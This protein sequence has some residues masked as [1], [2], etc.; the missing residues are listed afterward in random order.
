VNPNQPISHQWII[1][2]QTPN[3]NIKVMNNA[4]E[5]RPLNILYICNKEGEKGLW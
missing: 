1:K 2:L 5:L 4:D 3:I